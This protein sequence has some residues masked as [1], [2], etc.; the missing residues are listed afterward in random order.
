MFLNLVFGYPRII[1][2]VFKVLR[3]WGDN[4]VILVLDLILWNRRSFLYM[5][6]YMN[7]VDCLWV[8]PILASLMI[9]KIMLF[10]FFFQAI[11]TRDALAKSIY[12]CLFEWLVEQINKS[13]AVGKRRTGRS[14]SIL[15]IYGFESFDVCFIYVLSLSLS[16]LLFNNY[17]YRFNLFLQRNS[18]EQFCINYA[19]ERLQQHFNR[20]LFKLEQ[21]VL[22]CIFFV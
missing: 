12:A 6:K 3:K 5:S 20:H 21:E 2:K 11:D 19:N 16:P 10:F 9:E 1:V 7:M 8:W 14:I 4:L 15:D 17:L 22:S 18:F 13:L